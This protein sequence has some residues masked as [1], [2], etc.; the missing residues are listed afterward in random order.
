LGAETHSG[1]GGKKLDGKRRWGAR[2]GKTNESKIEQRKTRTYNIKRSQKRK[3]VGGGGVGS[4]G[5]LQK[6]G[7][8]KTVSA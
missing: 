4:G 6:A 7:E 3:M 2:G 8:N 1:G 5:A